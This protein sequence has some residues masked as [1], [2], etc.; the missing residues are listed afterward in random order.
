VVVMVVVVMVALG[1]DV[2]AKQV[3]DSA[4]NRWQTVT[5]W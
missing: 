1:V 2:S 3:E 4:I 5:A